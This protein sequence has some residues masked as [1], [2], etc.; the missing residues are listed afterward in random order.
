MIRSSVTRRE[1]RPTLS[2]QHIDYGESVSGP[3]TSRLACCSL[4]TW[5]GSSSD[6]RRTQHECQQR[7]ARSVENLHVSCS[8]R[9]PLP[10]RAG[11]G[12]HG[13]KFG[14]G[15]SGRVHAHAKV[16]RFLVFSQLKIVISGFSYQCIFHM[17]L[18]L[19]LSLLPGWYSLVRGRARQASSHAKPLTRSETTARL[20]LDPAWR[21]GI[22]T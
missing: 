2:R 16:Y 21:F 19:L 20:S 14:W 13:D 10:C 9:I 5:P 7:I 11:F 3:A 1:Q 12:A 4:G 6:T 8:K 17:M 22:L 15:G 18:D